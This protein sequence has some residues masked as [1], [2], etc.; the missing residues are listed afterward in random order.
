MVGNNVDF[1]ASVCPKPV[2]SVRR[3]LATKTSFVYR[4]GG[5][6]R[7]CTSDNRDARRILQVF[8]F[9]SS[10]WFE[11]IYAVYLEI[12]IRS[13][14]QLLVA[15]K[16]L[17]CLGLLPIIRVEIQKVSLSELQPSVLCQIGTTTPMFSPLNHSI[18]GPTQECVTCRSI[19]F[20]ESSNGMKLWNGRDISH[21]WK[22]IGV[23]V[24]ATSYSSI[25]QATLRPRIFDTAN[26]TCILSTNTQKLGS[27]NK[28]CPGGGL[29]DG[30][31]GAPGQIGENCNALGSKFLLTAH[32]T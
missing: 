22:S 3:R 5:G 23:T 11:N 1:E 19:D 29:G 7:G 24:V 32:Q 16:Y 9:G 6:C 30:D 13:L 28:L 12:K 31:A 18:I 2:A 8:G 17:H 26:S 4:G 21:E 20:S 15:P 27:P 14:I 10:E 25:I